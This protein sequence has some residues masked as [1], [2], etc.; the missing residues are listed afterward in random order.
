MWDW[1]Q[2]VAPHVQLWSHPPLIL[3][4]AVDLQAAAAATAQ[5]QCRLALACT[6]DTCNSSGGLATTG[7]LMLWKALKY[8]LAQW[9]GSHMRL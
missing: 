5:R 1:V 3:V 7:N 6:A 9:P 8:M 2:V 4:S